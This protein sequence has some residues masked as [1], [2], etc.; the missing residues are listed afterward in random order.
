ME[1]ELYHHP[2]SR[3]AITVWMLE[4]VGEPYEMH[5]V[6]LIAGDQRTNDHK[7]RNRMTKVPVL[8]VRE[9]YISESAA[10]GVYLADR[11]ALTR[12]APAL[13]DLRR[14]EYLRWCFFAPSVIEPACMAKSS[15]WDYKPASAGFGSYENMVA[16][17]EEAL[18]DRE[19]LLGAHF[20]MADV[21][22]GATVRSMFQ[23]KMMERTPAIGAYADRLG[24][25]DALQR[26]DAINARIAEE[27]GLNASPD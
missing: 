20:T 10:I 21:I 27:R 22:V 9:S 24:Q 12:L 26:A 23:F 2:W 25:R 14:G 7:G 16:T 19:F 13:D 1:I 17:L 4:E 18:T 15:G 3:A 11:F 8:K 6:D 5:Y